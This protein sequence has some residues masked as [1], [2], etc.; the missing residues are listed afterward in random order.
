MSRRELNI[1]DTALDLTETGFTVASTDKIYVCANKAR[2]FNSEVAASQFA[3]RAESSVIDDV[4]YWVMKKYDEGDNV[5][6]CRY[7][8]WDGSTFYDSEAYHYGYNNML[9]VVCSF[10]L[11]S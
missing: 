10:T 9:D 6:T 1:A 4:Q 3:R 8:G 11:A 5:M 2:A 7:A